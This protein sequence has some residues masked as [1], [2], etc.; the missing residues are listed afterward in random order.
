[1]PLLSLAQRRFARLPDRLIRLK[2]PYS[3]FPGLFV[4][5][6]DRRHRVGDNRVKYS[7]NRQNFVDTG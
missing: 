7:Q 1:M 6:L 2:A 4:P 3:Q 5:A